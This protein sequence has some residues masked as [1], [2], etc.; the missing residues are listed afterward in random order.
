MALGN[1]MEAN[2]TFQIRFAFL[3]KISLQML[4]EIISTSVLSVSIKT[5]WNLNHSQSNLWSR[6]EHGM[7]PC[8]LQRV[9]SVA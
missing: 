5:V 2:K 4:K 9:T 8:A 6:G 1:V 7:I 3:C